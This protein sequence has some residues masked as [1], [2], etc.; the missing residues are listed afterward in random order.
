MLRP[1]RYLLLCFALLALQMAIW[2]LY[3]PGL[4]E[5]RGGWARALL[6]IGL[7]A[8]AVHV[9]LL[10]L[11][12]L[13]TL[14]QHAR[15]LA[16]RTAADRRLARDLHDRVGSR[17]VNALAMTNGHGHD[18]AEQRMA[19]EL[20]LIEL[21][22]VVDSMHSPR[23]PVREQLAQLRYRLQPIF[24]HQGIALEWAVQVKKLPDPKQEALLVLV[25]Q[26]G[27]SNVLQHA[28]ASQVRVTLTMLDGGAGWCFEILDNGCGLKKA[29]EADAVNAGFGTTSMRE[30]L[31]EAGAELAFEPSPSGGLW[32]R[33][34]FRRQL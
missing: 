34:T 18:S 8:G 26:E 33:A 25:A 7:L 11:Q 6:L 29:P 13:N 16:K 28:H 24:E 3:G 15:H 23:R 4:W 5:K 21:R 30:R 1:S 14:H 20:V 27:L 32:L 10:L 9:V 12:F 17:L 19:L 22:T 2:A 31:Q